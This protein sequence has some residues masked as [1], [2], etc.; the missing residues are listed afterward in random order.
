[1]KPCEIESLIQ[2]SV[3]V[4]HVEVRN[5]QD[6]GLHFEAIVVSKAF[7]GKSLIEQH[8]LVMNALKGH[9]QTTLHALSLKTLTPKQ[10]DHRLNG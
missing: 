5:P 1:M 3:D 8:Q 6:D 2:K 7:E 10:W 4:A 9:F